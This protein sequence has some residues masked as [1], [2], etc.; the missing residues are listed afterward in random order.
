[1]II[2]V[3]VE[4]SNRNIDKT[5]SYLVP[6][7][8]TD[9]IKVGIRVLVPFG[10]QTLEGF[11]LNIKNTIDNDLELKEIIEV[12]DDEVILNKE[13]LKLGKY[14]SE[15]TLSTLISSYQVMLPK[16]LKAK[17]GVNISKK[18]DTY[19]TLNMKPTEKL[20]EAQTKII[21]CL[22]KESKVLKNKLNLISTSAVK[23]LLKKN[24]IKE[25]KEEHYRLISKEGKIEKKELTPLQKE[26]ASE[27]LKYKNNNEI[28]LLHGVTGSG[29][30]EV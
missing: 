4:L 19:I 29:K 9:K 21:D 6:S 22:S 28:F 26:V 27:V 17:E 1:M 3:L 25:I 7:S 14:I 18:I 5:F 12:I 23:T 11:V 24:I 13:L 20:T 16:A 2:E 30:T 15:S 8:L 10:K